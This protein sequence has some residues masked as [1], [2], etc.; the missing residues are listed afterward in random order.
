MPAIRGRF[1]LPG[2][3][4]AKGLEAPHAAAAHL[5][6]DLLAQDLLG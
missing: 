6:G 3:P 4:R 5:G 1:P 2:S